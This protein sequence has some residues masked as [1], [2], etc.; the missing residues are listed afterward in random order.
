[1]YIVHCQNCSED[2]QLHDRMKMKTVR[3]HICAAVIQ[4]GEVRREVIKNMNRIEDH[5]ERITN[6]EQ[7][8]PVQPILIPLFVPPI[9]YIHAPQCLCPVCMRIAKD[10]CGAFF[11]LLFLACVVALAWGMVAGL[12]SLCS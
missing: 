10:T 7:T 2:V 4:V 3:C 9:Q 8:Q 12:H 11:I 6:I 1:M 5:E